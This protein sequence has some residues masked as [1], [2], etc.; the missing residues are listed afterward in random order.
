MEIIMTIQHRTVCVLVFLVAACMVVCGTVLA[1]TSDRV[2]RID[3]I[4]KEAGFPLTAEQK[5]RINALGSGPESRQKMMDVLDTKQQEALRKNWNRPEGQPGGLR[6][7][8]QP[9]DRGAGFM[10]NIETTLQEAGCP[11]TDDQRKKL[12]AIEPGPEARDTMMALLTDQQKAV[13]EK[14]RAERESQMAKQMA[15]SLKYIADALKEAGC[16]LTDDQMQKIR[17]LQGREMFR[18]M[19]DILTD[20]QNE[21]FRQSNVMSI[22]FIAPALE[23]AG[24]PLTEDQIARIKALPAGRDEAARGRMM[25]ILTDKQRGVLE[26]QRRNR[27]F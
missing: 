4:L 21:A 11:L 26:N 16:P 18:G 24:C 7:Q 8:G 27:G 12:G 6:G 2:E 13:L 20:Q 5:E 9:R 17:E 1:Q 15:A 25:E 10:S 23:E 19:M 22:M 3:K 14:A